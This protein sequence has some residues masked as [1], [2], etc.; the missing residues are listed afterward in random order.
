MAKADQCKQGARGFTLIE[1]LIALSITGMVVGVLMNAVYYGAKV[2]ASVDYQLRDIEGRL[3]SKDWFVAVLS[4][5]IAADTP[6]GSRFKGTAK[7]IS[8]ETLM[9]LAGASH[10]PASRVRLQL[11]SA[12]GGATEMVYLTQT[13]AGQY[14]PS[15]IIARWPDRKAEFVFVNAKS[16]QVAVWPVKFD[17]V[18]TL[19]SRVDM[20][21]TL[22]GVTEPIEIWS[23]AMRTTAWVEPKSDQLPFGS[24]K[25][26]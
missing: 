14:S 17:D 26:P 12:E 5:C 6:S 21:F 25:I 10:L 18:E 3:R 22:E 4:G 2:E 11:I 16:A 19:P 9:P 1:V 7:E 13:T 23:A 20:R 15:Q 8:C 24:G